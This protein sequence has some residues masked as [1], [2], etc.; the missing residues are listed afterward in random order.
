MKPTHMRVYEIGDNKDG[1]T[2]HIVERPMPVPGYGEVLIKVM[3]TGL[4]ARD[5][6]I[7]RGLFFGVQPI[8]RVPLSDMAGQVVEVGPGVTRVKPGDRVTMTH[9]WRWID[10]AWNSDMAREDF[11][12]T[13]DGNLAEYVVRPAEPLIPIPEYLSYEECSTLQSAG[14]TAWNAVVAAGKVKTGE[15][16]VTIGTGGVSVFALQWAKMS[17]ART[18]VTSSSDAKLDIMRGHGA[19]FGINYMDHPNWA[20]HVLELTGGRGA[21]V[22]VNNVGIAEME[23]CLNAC[24]SGARVMYLGANPTARHR[25]PAEPTAMKRF[26]NLILKDL[27]IKGVIVGSRRM[28]EDMLAAMTLHGTKPI[29][30]RVYPFEQVLDAIRYMESG[31]KIGKIVIK[32]A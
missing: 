3:A 24:G 6:D 19:D 23:N 21:D 15:T 14:L 25:P 26:P 32:V 18:I 10:G 17:G 16:V 11:S 31:E 27:T 29:I 9:Y 20:E 30:D 28:F 7:I 4:N 1:L 12:G 13:L 8:T 2:L 22:V 5:L